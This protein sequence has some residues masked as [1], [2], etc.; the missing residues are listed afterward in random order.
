MSKLFFIILFIF[1]LNCL[2]S[3]ATFARKDLEKAIFAGGCFWC[4]E[5][6]FE[7]ISGIKDVISGYMVELLKIQAIKIMEELVIL[8]QC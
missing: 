6:D 7:K 8:K 5:S 4:M 1:G 3:P 2:T